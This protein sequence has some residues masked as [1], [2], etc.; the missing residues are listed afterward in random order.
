[1][2]YKYLRGQKIGRTTTRTKWMLKNINYMKAFS[3]FSQVKMLLGR[4][5]MKISRIDI[6]D[7]VYVMRVKEFNYLALLSSRARW[8]S[9]AGIVTK[10]N[11][12]WRM[13]LS[14]FNHCIKKAKELLDIVESGSKM[15]MQYI[16]PELTSLDT[17]IDFFESAPVVP[18]TCP[19]I[20]LKGSSYD[21][22]RQYAQQVVKIFGSWILEKKTGRIF[23]D[24]AL[25]TVSEW[26]KQM[27]EHTPEIIEMCRGWKDGVNDLGIPMSYNDVLEIWTGHVPPRKTYMGRGDKISDAP[28]PIAC[29]GV[30][31]WGTSTSDGELVT[32][33]SG[34]HDPSFPVV[35]TAYPDTGNNFM[36]VTFSAVGDITLVGSQHMFGFPGINNK[37]LAYIEH[38]GQPRSIEPKKYWG[39]GLRRAA[40][41]LHILRFADSAEQ[42]REM[43]K[44]WPVGDAG[45]DNGTI[46]GFYADRN[47]GYVLESRKDPVI[48]REAGHMGEKD[49]LYANNSA[50]HK[51]ASQAGWMKIDQ[52]SS[53]DWHWDE[54]GG[55]YPE[56]AEGFTLAALFKGGE[57]QAAW[58]LRGMY[59]G[60][61][62]RNNYSFNMLDSRKGK[63]DMEYMKKMYR[64]SA[65]MPDD[66][67]KQLNRKYKKSGAWGQASIGNCSNGVITITKPDNGDSGI[68][69]VCIGEAR[70]GINPSSPFLASFCPMYNSSNAFWEMKL[71]DSPEKAMKYA[72]EV[73]A[74]DISTV[75]KIIAKGKHRVT[76]RNSLIYIKDILNTG[77]SLLQ[78]GRE[79]INILS[80][81]FDDPDDGSAGLDLIAESIRYFIKAQVKVRTALELLEPSDYKSLDWGI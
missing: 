55:W 7:P 9:S 40:S 62:K 27:K 14:T 56:N 75:E 53:K 45:M 28:P 46:G 54:H 57:A 39:Y 47:Y 65:E 4:I 52:K 42:A 19:V 70:R 1:M 81:V 51:E 68:F 17:E 67:W 35:I 64:S 30:A 6:N 79:K 49:F 41:V 69:S 23:T 12:N 76:N 80:G 2:D 34:D 20:T 74:N 59:A 26:E 31:A 72:E 32:G 63:I 71:A 58:S 5:N 8:Y 38:G 33:S 3:K 61:R 73:A 36:Y 43:E 78:E 77:K 10:N 60:S 24:E 11:D 15:A 18:E 29:S 21:M 22:G 16:P 50:M 25:K 37:G 66:S 44:S 48:C 13:A